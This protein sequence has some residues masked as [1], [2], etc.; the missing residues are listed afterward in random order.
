MGPINTNIDWFA[1][2]DGVGCVDGVN[3]ADGIGC[4][5]G[6]GCVDVGRV[7]VRT[8]RLFDAV[9]VAKLCRSSSEATATLRFSSL[10]GSACR[11][12]SWVT[13]DL[14]VGQRCSLSILSIL[15][16]APSTVPSEIGY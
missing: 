15:V 8:M 16:H 4:V 7:G 13:R 3:R 12:S 11:T 5:G 6:I 9:F 2:S 14:L 10:V 1:S